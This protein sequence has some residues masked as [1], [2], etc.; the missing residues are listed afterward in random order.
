M[1]CTAAPPLA[2]ARSAHVARVLEKGIVQLGGQTRVEI[3]KVS[4]AEDRRVG[5]PRIPSQEWQFCRRARDPNLPHVR[6]AVAHV[7]QHVTLRAPVAN[8]APR[9]LP[10]KPVDR[11]VRIYCHRVRR[12]LGGVEDAVEA[13][14]LLEGSRVALVGRHWDDNRVGHRQLTIEKCEELQVGA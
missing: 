5:K 2:A 11:D 6:F 4:P 7:H 1:K 14:Q 12:R 13:L 8:V 3:I 10:L 9:A